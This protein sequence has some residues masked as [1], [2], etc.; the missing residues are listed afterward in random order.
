MPGQTDRGPAVLAVRARIRQRRHVERA[1]TP[2]VVRTEANLDFHLMARRTAGLGLFS[3]EH[4]HRG[5]ARLHRDERGVHLAYRGLLRAETAADARLLHANAALRDAQ[6]MGQDAAD[7]EHDLRGRDHMQ[8]PVTVELGVRTEGLHHGLV[9]GLRV[10]SALQNDVAVGKHRL[11]VAVGVSGRAHEVSLV[12]SAQVAQHMPVVLGV[13]EGGIVL[14]SA[15]IQHGIEHLV[16][17][18]NARKG[19][20]GS[21][22]VFR[23]DNR[24]HVAHVAH[25]AIDDQAVVGACLRIGLSRVAEALPRHVFPGE[26]THHAGNLLRL[27]R[28]DVLHDGVGMRT[29]QKLHHERVGRDVLGEHRLAQKEL[30]RVLLADG[31]AD[32]LVVG[33]IHVSSLPRFCW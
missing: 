3:C 25:M 22:L 23:G 10:V 5:A 19:R 28:V 12:V 21:L 2:V 9:E 7:V 24:H 30:Q 32:R 27:R 15:E 1:D 26:H 11:D 33:S 16:G 17:H 31:L 4:A 6:R 18:L 13:H 29:P 8:A 14:S 20:L